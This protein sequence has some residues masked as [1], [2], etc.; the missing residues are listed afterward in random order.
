[1]EEEIIDEVED[2]VDEKEDEISEESFLK[3][4]KQ[5]SAVR[6]AQSGTDEATTNG[7]QQQPTI[8]KKIERIREGIVN[9]FENDGAVPLAGSLKAQKMREMQE[10]LAKDQEQKYRMSR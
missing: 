2:D 10:K 3:E 8:P 9:D 5:G 7:Q 6:K 1:M 4:S